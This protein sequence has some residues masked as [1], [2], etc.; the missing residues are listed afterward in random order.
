MNW[1]YNLKLSKKLLTCFLCLAALAAWIGYLGASSTRKIA[2]RGDS[3]YQ[4]LLSVQTIESADANFL[5]ARYRTRAVLS[6]TAAQRAEHYEA[7]RTAFSNIDQ[8]L[9]AFLDLPMDERERSVM[10]RVQSGMAD[11]RRE[12]EPVYT[13]TAEGKLNE[14]IAV[15][16]GRATEAGAR[17]GKDLDELVQLNVNSAEQRQKSNQATADSAVQLMTSFVVVGVFGALGLGWVLTRII[18]GPI[19]KLQAT[20]VQ[21]ATGNIEVEITADSKDEIGQLA[22]SFRDLAEMIKGRAHASERIAAGDLQLEVKPASEKDIL[23]RSMQSV[24]DTLGRLV[25]E[26]T[27]MSSAHDEGDIDAFIDA[28]KFRGAYS[29]VATGLNKMVAGHIAVKKKAMACIAEFARGNFEAPLERFPGKKAFINENIEQLRTNLKTLIA[30]MNA[31]SSAHDAGDID[32]AI[33]TRKFRGAFEEVAAGIN[34]MVSGHI[35]VKRKA[36]ACIAEFGRGNFEA[37]LE[38]FPGKKA[39]INET[40]EQVRANLKLLVEDV[41]RLVQAADKG[42]LSTRADASRH[43][44][45]YRRIVQGINDTLESVIAPMKDVSAVLD[46]VADG[47]LTQEIISDYKGDFDALK[48]SVNKLIHNVGDT[49][50]QITANADQLVT[51]AEELNRVSQQMTASADETATQANVVSAASE[52]VSR[53]VQTVASGAD[54]MGASIKEIAK[55]T[56][57][58]TRVANSAVQTAETTNHTIGKLGQSSAEIGQVIKVI[59]SI[60]QQTNLLALNATIEAA[61]AGE[62]GKG[63]AVVANEVKEL[64]K[65]TAKATED[66][67]RKIEAIQSDTTGAVAAIAEIGTVINQI[68]DIQT[69]IASAVEEQSVTSNEISRNLAEA[70]KGNVDITRNVTGVA[71]A[72]RVTTSGAAETQKSAKSLEEMAIE[73]K[74]LVSRF[75]YEEERG[76]SSYAASRGARSTSSALIQ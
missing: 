33:D 56:A 20:A 50:H 30:D 45:D 66:I 43:A 62:A 65:E 48:R 71:E 54:Q 74:K 68:S 64:A 10:T 70:A 27:R 22:R 26:M 32:A 24:V 31:M 40:I 8:E 9:K 53:N 61:R 23:A 47:D 57:E 60:A 59:T 55:N 21:L 35:S 6:A 41:Q 1:F 15:A 18:V 51:S 36:M 52:Q 39:F 25:E 2:A 37:P 14:A 34:N 67:G 58:A 19:T 63:F 49:I 73:L 4:D 46:R 29:N 16:N 44:G 76:V 75:R 3:L 13:L 7:F 11:Y 72:A 38:K 5:Q 28:T 42:L 12:A 17:V 69:T